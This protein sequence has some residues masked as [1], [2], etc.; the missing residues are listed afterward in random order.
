MFD[1]NKLCFVNCLGYNKNIVGGKG[2]ILWEIKT[3]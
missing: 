1:R 3:N 2:E